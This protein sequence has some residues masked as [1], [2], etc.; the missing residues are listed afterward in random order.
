MIIY[1][2]EEYINFKFLII[3][4][5][6]NIAYTNLE[7]T[8]NTDSIEKIKEFLRIN[9]SNIYWNYEEGLVSTNISKLTLENIK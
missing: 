2:S 4:K 7:H 9:S 3:D 6:N 1:V 8:M 5:N